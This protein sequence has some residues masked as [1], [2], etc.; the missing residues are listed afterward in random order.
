MAD[1]RINPAKARSANLSPLM[2]AKAK[3]KSGKVV[4]FCPFGCADAELDTHGYCG[5]LIGTTNEPRSNQYE[6]MVYDEARGHRITKVR[7]KIFRGREVPVLE[8][9]Q[10]GDKLVRIT[11]SYRV[12]R[13]VELPRPDAED[14]L[15]EDAPPESDPEML[16]LERELAAEEA[17]LEAAERERGVPEKNV[18]V[19]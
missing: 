9:M 13:N 8:K 5:H 19:E 16:A 11:T 2:K 4:N 18:T 7:T 1:P 3:A 10:S 17:A 6:P 15:D 14:V 12:Y